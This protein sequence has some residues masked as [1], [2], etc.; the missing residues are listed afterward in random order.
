L[1]PALNEGE[2]MSE[3]R[4]GWDYQDKPIANI[5]LATCLPGQPLDIRLAHRRLAS[6][7]AILLASEN[8]YDTWKISVLTQNTT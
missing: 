2:T 4:L 5:E 3:M 7:T 8:Q 6:Q 1:S